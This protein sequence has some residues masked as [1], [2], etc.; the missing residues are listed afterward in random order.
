MATGI[1]VSPFQLYPPATYAD[2]WL[3]LWYMPVLCPSRRYVPSG[4]NASLSG[5][6]R[7]EQWPTSEIEALAA[8]TCDWLGVCGTKTTL[9]FSYLLFCCDVPLFLWEK[10][11][12]I[13]FIYDL[14]E[15]SLWKYVNINNNISISVFLL[16]VYW[17][18]FWQSLFFSS[19]E[20]QTWTDGTGYCTAK[21]LE[22]CIQIIFS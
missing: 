13:Q 21:L 16:M 2:P 8:D 4:Y 3:L 22:E 19:V 5:Q 9:L 15:R 18:W 1:G 11:L 12:Q 14:E 6:W 10:P 17:P 7:G 20:E